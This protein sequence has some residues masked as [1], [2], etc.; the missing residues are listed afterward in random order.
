MR[1]SARLTVTAAALG[2]LWSGVTAAATEQIV[3]QQSAGRPAMADCVLIT[4]ASQSSAT[5]AGISSPNAVTYYVAEP[6]KRDARDAMVAPERAA[7]I[8]EA[9][10]DLRQPSV[11]Q[12]YPAE[13]SPRDGK[14][15]V[16]YIVSQRAVPA[17]ASSET[18][19]V[20][21]QRIFVTEPAP[22][23]SVTAP[24]WPD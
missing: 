13:S 18:L 3:C 17:S 2:T 7:V 19:V 20:P 8:A 10:P 11:P 22:F 14:P 21:A 5:G 12:P 24:P 4:P 6:I 15:E 23:P 16:R 9:A 1:P